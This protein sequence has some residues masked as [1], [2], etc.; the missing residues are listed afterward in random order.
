MYFPQPL[1]IAVG[2]YINLQW[3]SLPYGLRFIYGE[4]LKLYS[5][6]ESSTMN[7]IHFLSDL[8]SLHSSNLKLTTPITELDAMRFWHTWFGREQCWMMPR[9]DILTCVSLSVRQWSDSSCLQAVR[10]TA[11]WH[12]LRRWR[13]NCSADSDKRTGF[14]IEFQIMHVKA[15]S[16]RIRAPPNNLCTD[17]SQLRRII[18]FK[19]SIE[20]LESINREPLI[21]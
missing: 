1:Q 8:T 13:Y 5:V 3:N 10:G 18:P 9:S 20:R 7:H 21:N 11:L 16:Q 17:T 2:L 19:K 14:E 6:S 12:S 4:I 15:S